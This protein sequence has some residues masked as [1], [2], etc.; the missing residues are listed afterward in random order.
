[1]EVTR[2][3]PQQVFDRTR[4]IENDTCDICGYEKVV[5]V[6]FSP[7]WDEKMEFSHQYCQSCLYQGLERMKVNS[8]E[9][10]DQIR[11]RQQE[12]EKEG[13][14]R[15]ASYRLADIPKDNALP[16]CLEISRFNNKGEG[17]VPVS[18]EKAEIRLFAR[19]GSVC[20]EVYRGG[21]EFLGLFLTPA[22]AER[23]VKRL[24]NQLKTGNRDLHF[25]VIIPWSQNVNVSIGVSWKH[26][27][28]MQLHTYEKINRTYEFKVTSAIY[29]K[30]DFVAGEARVEWE[31]ENRPK[32]IHADELDRIKTAQFREHWID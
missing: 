7:F 8:N 16:V 5:V 30:L 10:T 27:L 4:L 9:T 21:L 22:Q 11:Q 23:L 12:T 19:G 25:G 6:S 20:F 1:M 31:T 2:W 26:G 14:N 15:L 13:H 24:E 17:M 32:I 29:W 18:N 28:T 3:W